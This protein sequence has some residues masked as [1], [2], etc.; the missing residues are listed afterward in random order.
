MTIEV[1]FIF[2]IIVAVFIA[3][4]LEKFPPNVVALAASAVL[5]ATGILETSE[6]LSVFSNSAPITIAMMF[7]ISASLERTGILQIISRF[8]KKTAKDSSLKFMLVMMFCA[9][10]ASAFMNNTPIVILMTPVVISLAASLNIAPSRLLIPLSFSAIFGGT[11]TLV[12]TSTNILINSVAKQNGEAAIGMFEMTLPGL[13]F[14]AIG[15]IY[16]V[17]AGRFLLVDRYSL[18]SLVAEQPRRQFLTE[19]LI[20]HDSKYIGKKISELKDVALKE[21]VAILDIVRG[22]KSL[23]RMQEDI[24]M[25]VGDR[26][27]IEANAGHLVGLKENGQ[28]KIKDSAT[29]YEAIRSD[30]TVVVEASIGPK[31]ALIGR[32]IINLGLARKY[33]VYVIAVHRN[34]TNMG[35][36]FENLA[37]RFADT[38]LLEGS[39]ESIKR[40]LDEGNV[41]NLSEAEERP[42]RRHKAPI[43]IAVIISVMSLAALNVMPIAGLAIIGAVIV[44]ITGCVD[45][46][47]AYD[48]IDWPILFLIFGMLGLSMGMEKTGAAQI[49]VEVVFALVQNI[50]PLAILLS[51]YIL[52]SILTEMVSNNAVAVLIAPIVI[53]LAQELGLDARPFIMAVLFASSASFAT[54]IG[55]QTN[56]FVYGAGGYKFKDFLK[57]GLPLNIIFAL[58]SL[59]IIPLFFPF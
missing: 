18:S 59:I 48:A 28:L 29:G 6:I 40:L 49:I 46:D 27:V 24:L 14:A 12:G 11:L 3:F 36:D 25:E 2:F 56:T 53:G 15:M 35:H 22:D 57:V 21:E 58:A 34:D 23:R 1:I 45:A 26:L 39:A 17:F 32:K 4:I 7:I 41:I 50:G 16:M 9:G 13:I 31:S 10:I 44:M 42:I 38:L 43:A 19:V 20:S 37:L 5:L 51:I 52:T 8:L 47:E 55:Y 54:P 30:E 33:G